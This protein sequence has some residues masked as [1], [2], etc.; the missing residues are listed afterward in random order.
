MTEKNKA[1]R[2]SRRDFIRTTGAGVLT[3]G[4][5][6]NIGVMAQKENPLD[7]TNID[8]SDPNF[9]PILEDLQG[10]IL[11]SHG[12]DHSVHIF[13][14][15]RSDLDV[16]NKW[17]RSFAQSYITSAKK[18]AEDAERYRN[19]IITGGLFTTFF[20]SAPGYRVLEFPLVKIPGSRSFLSG[21]KSNFTRV[22]LKDPEVQDWE[23]GFQDEIHAL[24]GISFLAHPTREYTS[25]GLQLSPSRQIFSP[26][27]CQRLP[28]A[29]SE[30]PKPIASASRT[31]FCRHLSMPGGYRNHF[32]GCAA[33]WAIPTEATAHLF[34]PAC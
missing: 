23:E 17:I 25:V 21:M 5:S 31:S 3:A 14:K 33:G 11:A 4:V 34:A 30:S 26:R 1:K 9:Q 15:F 6:A 27:Y 18:Q 7:R 8:S 19:E 22:K 2:I 28:A 13:L 24:T 12:R 10:N 32:L 16:T 29:L 20:L